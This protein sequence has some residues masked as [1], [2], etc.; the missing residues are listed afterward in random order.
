MNLTKLKHDLGIDQKDF[1]IVMVA[2]FD[3][4]KRHTIAFTA[5]KEVIKVNPYV[6]LLLVGDGPLK[7]TLDRLFKEATSRKPCIFPRISKKCRY[8]LS[9]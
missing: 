5:L 9:N 7:E 6:K 8:V 4:V 1:V 2:R 3:P